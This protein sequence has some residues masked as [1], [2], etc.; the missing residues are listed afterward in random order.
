M[1]VPGIELRGSCM[2]GKF[3]TTE[4]YHRP[5][6]INFLNLSYLAYG[7]RAMKIFDSSALL[8]KS[9]YTKHT[10]THTLYVAKIPSTIK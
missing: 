6:Y 5:I 7:E 1:V 9:S 10:H 2:L 8:R 4:L 3:N